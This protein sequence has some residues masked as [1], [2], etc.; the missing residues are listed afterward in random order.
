MPRYQVTID[1][2]EYD[3]TLEYR[4][5]HFFATI[6][7]KSVE[8]RRFGL[9]ETRSLLLIDNESIEAD[10]HAARNGDKS[11]FLAGMEIQ[12]EIEDF[13]LA[14]MRKAAGVS[15][16]PAVEPLLRAPMPGLV[17]EIRVQPGDKVVKGQ[18]LI[19][20]EAMKMENII[21]ARGDAQVKSIAAVKG[22]S[23]EKGDP[24]L[25]FEV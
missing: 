4:S 23:V 10:V 3:V 17:V 5:E 25:E 21:K 16:G 22:N 9:G 14:Q 8:I 2:H 18:P 19:V 20:I 11:V 15:H 6:N 1:G 13:H 12:A 24:L 7:G